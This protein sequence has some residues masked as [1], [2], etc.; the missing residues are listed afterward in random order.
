MKGIE[1]FVA[2]LVSAWIET[3]GYRINDRMTQVALLVSAW[4]ETLRALR[5]KLGD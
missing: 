5:D 1:P 3:L 2:L 4:I